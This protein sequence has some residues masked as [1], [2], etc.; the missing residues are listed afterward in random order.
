MLDSLGTEYARATRP[1]SFLPPNADPIGTVVAVDTQGRVYQFLWGPSPNRD[2]SYVQIARRGVDSEYAIV[3]DAVV[4]IEALADIEDAPRTSRTP[5][6]SVTVTV[7]RAEP[8]RII[9]TVSPDGEL[10]VGDINGRHLR[11]LSFRGDTLRT[12]TPADVAGER[13]WAELDVSP[14][15][16][17]W[18][19][20]EPDSDES[21]TWDLLDNCG[22]YRGFA[23]VPHRVSL[24][25]VGPAGLIHVVASGAP[26]IPFIS[27]LR[28]DVD[29]T[30]Q[31]C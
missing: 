7:K 15:G 5:G 19:R 17:F 29:V 27:R 31:S 21:S 1:P 11:Q 24:T 28:V 26:D 3:P 2:S 13:V 20:R 22:A 6:G 4:L 30:R 18:L 10:W 14:E 25:S 23:S 8:S 9:G 12:I 16:W